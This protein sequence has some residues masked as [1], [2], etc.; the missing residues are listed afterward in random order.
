M[1]KPVLPQNIRG[2]SVCNRCWRL[3]LIE[4]SW[5]KRYDIICRK[6]FYWMDKIMHTKGKGIPWVKEII[7]D[8][9]VKGCGM[10]TC[11]IPIKPV[12]VLLAPFAR[13][14]EWR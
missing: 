9:V 5:A 10:E 3:V 11:R 1:T 8:D 7:Y 6:C 2:C 14:T 13:E 4:Y 12:G